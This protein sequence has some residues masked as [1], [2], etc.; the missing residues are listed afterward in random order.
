M[1]FKKTQVVTW[2]TIFIAPMNYFCALLVALFMSWTTVQC[3][4]GKT[5]PGTTCMFVI[6]WPAIIFVLLHGR[7]IVLQMLSLK[8]SFLFLHNNLALE[9]R[10]GVQELHHSFNIFLGISMFRVSHEVIFMDPVFLHSVC[11]LSRLS[12]NFYVVKC[13]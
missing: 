10:S 7:Q 4:F 1:K 12:R 13:P 6:Q 9:E 8:S 2:V 5:K 11:M 3:I